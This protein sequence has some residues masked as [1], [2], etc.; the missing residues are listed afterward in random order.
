[1]P[2][3]NYEA[4]MTALQEKNLDF[5]AVLRPVSFLGTD[6]EFHDTKM[7]TPV[8]SDNGTIISQHTFSQAYHPIQNRD[9]FR[10]I[11][12]ISELADV[13]FKNV[14]CW[15]NGAGVYAQI[16]LGDDIDVGGTGDHVGRYLSVVNSHDGTRGC[17]ILI[18]PYRFWC[19]NQITPAI[20]HA[21]DGQIFSIRHN[22]YA[23]DRLKLL[24]ESL[25]VCNKV[26]IRTADTYNEL[27]AKVIT[28]DEVRETM[29]RVLP[30]VADNDQSGEGSTHWKKMLTGMTNRFHSADGGNVEKMTA[31]NLYNSIQGTFQHDTRNGANKEFSILCGG[32]ASKS[33]HA[34]K[35]VVNL[36][37][38]GLE[39]TEHPQFDRFFAQVA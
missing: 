5:D 29:A 13:E 35:T 28:M 7:F 2:N 27:A 37:R 21:E 30:F 25:H 8:R 6:G 11:A 3:S 36:A 23:G 15:G 31:W 38:E 9:A 19:Q 10:V 26:F 32:I 22:S 14:G 1:M 12:D 39:K 33:A 24:A 16:A 34:F 4:V 17:S 18:T 20:N